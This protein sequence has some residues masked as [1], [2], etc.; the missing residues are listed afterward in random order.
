MMVKRREFDLGLEEMQ[1][2]LAEMGAR[3]DHALTES[4]N[5]LKNGDI[6]TARRIVKDD[7]ELNQME[8]RISEIGA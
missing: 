8:E 2:L 6:A 7:P 5:A 3:V 1:K 4:M